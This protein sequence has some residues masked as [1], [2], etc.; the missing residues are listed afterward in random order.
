MTGDV[1][2]TCGHGRGRRLAIRRARSR[3]R[4][5]DRTGSGCSNTRCSM[6]RAR[7]LI[8][9]S[10]SSGRSSNRTSGSWRRRSTAPSRRP[11][12]VQRLD[13]LPAGFTAGGRDEAVG[14]RP[15]R[16]HRSRRRQDAVRH[17]ERRRFLRRRGVPAGR[18]RPPIWPTQTASRASSRCGSIDTLSPFGPVKRGWCQTRDGHV[19]RLEEV[20]GIERRGRPARGGRAGTRR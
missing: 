17:H 20:M 1:E 12:V 7:D 14:D 5:S 6:P 16:A 15:G 18:R 8:A 4:R 3:R 10:A 13:D 2:D 11:C 19:T 9:R